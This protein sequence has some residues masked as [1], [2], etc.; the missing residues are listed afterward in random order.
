MVGAILS[1]PG[2]TACKGYENDTSFDYTVTTPPV[3][4]AALPPHSI[5]MVVEG[6]DVTQICDTILLKKTPGCYTYG[7]VRESVLDV[8]GLA[9]DIGYFFP[10]TVN[11]GVRISLHA[12]PGYS[13]AVADA[14]RQS[15]ANYINGL[16]S[17]VDV[18]YSKLFLPAN[19]C[20][21]TGVPSGTTNTYDIYAMIQGTPPDNLAF[22]GYAAANVPIKL[23]EVAVCDPADVIIFVG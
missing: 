6:G 18:V 1:L 15:V 14:I 23:L 8:Y 10:S 22:A 2:V 3:G 4:Q 12:K 5:S 16:G 7:N 13:T 17:G 19:L 20:D 11:I 21:A 9:H